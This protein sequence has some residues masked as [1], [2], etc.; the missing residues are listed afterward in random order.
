[1]SFVHTCMTL[2]FSFFQWKRR[3]FEKC[4]ALSIQCSVLKFIDF[5]VKMAQ[6]TRNRAN[7]MD[8]LY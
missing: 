2:F 6:T 5:A 1:M 4:M 7:I 3:H 8:L